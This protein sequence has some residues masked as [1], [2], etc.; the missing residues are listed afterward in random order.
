MAFT[1]TLSIVGAVALASSLAAC[2]SSSSGG[3]SSAGG[4][5]K[6]GNCK[7]TSKANS[8]KITPAVKD[9]LTVETTLP[10]QG[11]WNGTTASSIKDGY[12]YCMAA[13]LANM[14]GLKKLS[15]K[16]VSFDQLVAGHTNNFDIALAEISITP[17]RAKVVD[18]SKPYFD[19]NIGVL[20]KK[21]AGVTA[22][23]IKSKRCAAYS[24][25]TS[26]DFLK[27]KLKCKTQKVYPDNQTLYQG[28]LSGQSDVALLDT[29]IVL[30]EAKQTGGKLEVAGQYKTGEKYGAIYPKGSANEKEFD[31][32][33]TTLVNDGTLKTLSKDYL[34][35]AFGGDP[36]AVPVWTVK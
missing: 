13:E 15:I 29:A 7:I 5:G 33:I 19:S 23:N 36:A 3:G 2:G 20:T 4:S 9:T 35:P 22:D 11:W 6:Y 31:K 32:G 14:A 16:N 26:V 10:A 17:A 18:F 34:G 25:T 28:V 30:A 12:E 21:G 27:N 24:G 1:R 8:I